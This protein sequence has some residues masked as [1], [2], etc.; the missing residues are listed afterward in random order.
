[1]KRMASFGL[2]EPYWKTERAKHHLQE[3]KTAIEHFSNSKPYIISAEDDIENEVHRIRVK[4]SEPHCWIHLIAGDIFYCLRSALDQAVYYLAK[5]SFPYPDWTQFPIFD[6]DTAETRKR[7]A[8]YTRGVDS[9][10]VSFIK[11]LQPYVGLNREP[12]TAHMLWML[13][14][15]CNIDKHRRIPIR[16][17]AT[18]ISF[19]LP[20]WASVTKTNEGCIITVPP[21]RKLEVAFDPIFSV[22]VSFGDSSEGVEIGVEGIEEIYNFVREYVLPRL[23]RFCK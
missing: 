9:E 12:L 6:E 2:I 1:M 17:C 11:S 16:G 19:K 13:N 8:R 22:D 20:P 10:A 23:A 5:D 4:F 15:M 18:D 14:K 7:F 21:S 3:L